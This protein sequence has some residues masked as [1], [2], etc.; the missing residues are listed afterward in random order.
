MS[1][2]ISVGPTRAEDEKE[3]QRRLLSKREQFMP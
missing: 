3:R 2:L 1:I